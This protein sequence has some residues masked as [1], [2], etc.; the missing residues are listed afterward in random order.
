MAV[1]YTKLGLNS[2]TAPRTQEWHRNSFIGLINIYG[3]TA[4]ELKFMRNSRMYSF[5]LLQGFRQS[6]VIKEL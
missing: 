6:K 2:E 4:E 3:I 5:G 1:R